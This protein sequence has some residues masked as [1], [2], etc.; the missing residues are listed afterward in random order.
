MPVDKNKD[1]IKGNSIHSKIVEAISS[2]FPED[3]S[4]I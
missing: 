3:L 4:P 1:S 2:V